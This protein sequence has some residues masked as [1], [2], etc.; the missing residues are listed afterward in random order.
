MLINKVLNNR[1]VK[2]VVYN[3]ATVTGLMLCL[4]SIMAICV[5]V[6]LGAGISIYTANPVAVLGGLLGGISA[7]KRC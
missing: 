7:K 4:L 1:L 3:N 6:G 5:V 2:W